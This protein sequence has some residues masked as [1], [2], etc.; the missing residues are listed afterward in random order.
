MDEKIT[1][2]EFDKEYDAILQRAEIKLRKINAT[3]NDSSFTETLEKKADAVRT[4]LSD[5]LDVLFDRFGV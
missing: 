1:A 2:D 3:K 5:E 4:K